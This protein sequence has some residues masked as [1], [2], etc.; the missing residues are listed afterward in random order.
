MERSLFKWVDAVEVL[1]G[2]V[3]EKE[4]S[5]AMTVAKG[6]GLPATGGSDAHE[7]AEVGKYANRF[8]DSINNEKDLIKALKSGN[9][10]PVA[11]R[12]EQGL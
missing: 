5:F 7:V 3:T 10:S 8:F 6:I 9:Y 1:N 11:F 12:K 2:K 4:N